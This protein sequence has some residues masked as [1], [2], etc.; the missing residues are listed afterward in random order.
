MK[1]IEE[2]TLENFNHAKQVLDEAGV[3][4]QTN[5]IFSDYFSKELG[6]GNE[7]YFKPENLQRTGSYKIRG[8]YYKLSTLNEEERKRGVIAASA[9]NHAQ[10]VGLAAE[11]MGVNAIIVMPTVAPVIKRKNTSSYKGVEVVLHGENYDGSYAHARELEKKHGYTYVHA[12]DDLTVATGQGTCALEILEELEADII[13]VPI[14]GGG[15]SAGVATYAKLKNPNIIIIGVEP[16]GAA[17]V[18]M[19]F[20]K[21]EV[22]TLDKVNTIADG[23]QIARAGDS[24]FPYLRKNI[25]HL[26]SIDDEELIETNLEFIEIGKL[27]AEPAGILTAAALKKLSTV[28]PN[29]KNKKIVSII[30]GGNIDANM[31]SLYIQHGLRKRGRIFS[32]SSS[33][34]QQPGTLNAISKIIAN[35]GG[36]ILEIKHDHFVSVNKNEAVEVII[37]LEVPDSTYRDKIVEELKKNYNINLK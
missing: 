28:L 2:L 6:E 4:R 27:I 31:I 10:G 23:A 5:L 32:F 22:K 33:I 34:P 9:G 35:N 11:A 16:A 18:H 37:T 26:M 14:G 25:D 29:L 21:G 17:C 19:A 3:L 36:N 24:V 20:D 30:S 13:L 7:V 12:Y 1:K 15:L 8:A